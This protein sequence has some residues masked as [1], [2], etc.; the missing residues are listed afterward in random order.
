MLELDPV[1]AL[2]VAESPAP[3]GPV[4]VIDD[5][6][7]LAVEAARTGQRVIAVTDRLDDE[8]ALRE[9][10]PS[11]VVLDRLTPEA[12]AE[13]STVWWRLPRARGALDETAAV[14][15]GA[16]AAGV[17]VVG[18]GRVKHMTVSMNDVLRRHFSEVRASRG[19]RKCRVLHAAG[20]RPGSPAASA[21]SA[22]PRSATVRLP[23]GGELTVCAHG[24][25]FAG[26]RL[27]A[28]TRL[29]LAQAD[30]GT[31]PGDALDLGCGS[32][33]LACQL[34][35]AGWT[36]HASD[37]STAAVLS[38]RA[39]AAVNGLPVRTHR[40]EGLDAWP[41]HSLD[42]IVT[43]PPFHVHGA[44]DSTPTLTMFTTAASVLRPGGQLIAVWNAHLPYLTHLREHVGRT[45]IVARDRSYVVT[46][47][48]R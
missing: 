40:A 12:L 44:K 41:P 18:G 37:I 9:A 5:H 24:A 45:T 32:G 46:R 29:L 17:D 22:W 33:I 26:T 7:P 20:P 48:H 19:V 28:G 39:T 16:A 36:A 1:A 6:G 42:L 15:A 8:R 47:T 27:D 11:A 2:I 4:L 35:R 23:D 3:S 13:V 30:L 14:V 21:A 31:G 43:N 38:T 34:A 10:C 25:A